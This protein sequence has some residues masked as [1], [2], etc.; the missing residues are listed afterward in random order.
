MR[1]YQVPKVHNQIIGGLERCQH[2]RECRVRLL[3]LLTLS[4][5][6]TSYPSDMKPNCS[7]LSYD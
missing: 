6:T 7:G 2:I 5:S 1:D 3:A 4:P